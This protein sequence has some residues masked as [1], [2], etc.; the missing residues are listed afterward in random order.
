MATTATLKPAEVSLS[1]KREIVLKRIFNAPQELVFKAW[2]Q[3]EFLT[4]WWAPKSFTTPFVKVDLHP[5]GIFHF[6]MRSSEGRD[7]W[8]KSVYRE[9]V[10]PELIAYTD[11][12]SDEAGALVEPE[13]YG[14][15]KGYPSRALVTVRFMGLRGKTEVTLRHAIPESVPERVPCEQGWVEMLDRLAEELEKESNASREVAA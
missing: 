8:G 6:C 13:R 14:M 15:S 4:R 1:N 3:E 11:S 9:I 10:E 2:T 5:G 7:F 12:F